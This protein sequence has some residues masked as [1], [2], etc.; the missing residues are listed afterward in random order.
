MS[1]QI[2]TESEL[3]RALGVSRQA[4]AKARKIGRITP[5]SDGRYDLAVARIQWEENRQ[6]RPAR[7]AMPDQLAP[8]AAAPAAA[9]GSDYWSHKTRR[10]AAEARLAELKL[11]ESSGLLVARADVERASFTAA[12]VMRDQLTAASPRLAAA[13]VGLADV[14][15]I[16]RVI[17]TEHRVVLE[18]FCQMLRVQCPH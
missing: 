7:P 12:R 1:A 15:A 8:D 2:V 13:V 11:A 14:A 16:E 18:T 17:A 9:D 10:E 4:V 6:R 5:L 3:A